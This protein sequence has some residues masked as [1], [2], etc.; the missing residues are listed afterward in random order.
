MGM[1]L[2]VLLYLLL[3]T[4]GLILIKT[5]LTQFPLEAHRLDEYRRLIVEAYRHPQLIVGLFLYILSFLSWLVLLSKKELTIV[6]PLLT[7]L[8]YVTIII[9]S[10]IF[11]REEIGLFKIVGIA[12]IAAGILFLIRP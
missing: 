5:W 7:G 9:A 3:S 10:V 8:S 2:L 12:L 1:A 11:L 4:A 6:F